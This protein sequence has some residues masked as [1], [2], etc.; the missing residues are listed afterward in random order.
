MF[1]QLKISNFRIFDDEVTI[2][3]RPITVLIGKNNAGKSSII[4][5]LLMLQQSLSLNSRA[6]L[7]TQGDK[8]RFG[9]FYTLRSKN[10]QKKYLKFSLQINQESSPAYYLAE[11]VNAYLKDKSLDK[12]LDKDF[13][14]HDGSG[15]YEIGANILYHSKN[16]LQGK[17]SDMRFLMPVEGSIEY[18]EILHCS[19]KLNDDSRFLNFPD[20]QQ[21]SVGVEDVEKYK[22]NLAEQDCLS[23]LAQHITAIKHIS[24]VKQDMVRSFDVNENILSDYVGKMG[25][26][27]L[28]HLQKLLHEKNNKYEFIKPHMNNIIDIDSISFRKLGDLAQC[29][30]RNKRTGD[31][32]NISD[33]GFGVSQCLPVLAQGAIMNQNTTLIVEQPEAQVH[34]TAQLELGSFFA[35][36]WKEKGVRSIIETHSNNILL[37]LRKLVAEGILK[38]DD[39]SIAFFDIE[40]GKVIINNLD[41]NKN[42][43]M[44][45]GLPMEF[46]GADI[47]EGLELGKAKFKHLANDDE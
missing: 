1:K 46:F 12:K 45:D 13:N 36:L 2:R 29:N 7:D 14:L 34:P 43:T 30:A 25:E 23:A 19:M 22:Q 4:K 28:H 42:G 41:I 8:V 18:Q 17:V 47:I 24:P 27:T 3:F 35:A 16:Y 9:N 20:M 5:F 11:Y 37:R 10:T 44:E 40:N 38:P 39:I 6:F 26:Y 21:S 33:F 31:K 15:Y 32:V